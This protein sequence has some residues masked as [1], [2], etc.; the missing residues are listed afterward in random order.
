MLPSL[1]I[2]TWNIFRKSKEITLWQHIVSSIT[3]IFDNFFQDAFLFVCLPY[4]AYYSLDAI[5]RTGWRMIISHKKLLE[6]TPSN[7]QEHTSDRT[8]ATAYWSMWF[9]PALA[10]ASFVYITICDPTRLFFAFPVLALWALSPFVAWWVSK[11]FKKYESKLTVVQV[12]YL[13]KIARKTWAFFEN[14]VGPEDNWLPVDNYQ[15]RPNNAVAH[16]TSPTNI[17]L[18]LLA[19]LSAYDFGYIT[20]GRLLRN[21]SNTINT[22]GKMERYEGHLYNWY[23]TVTLKPLHPRYVSTVDSGNLAGHLL[24][25]KQG[26]LAIADEKLTPRKLFEGLL[27]TAAIIETELP[28]SA[29]LKEL[30]NKIQATL[31]EPVISPGQAISI[32]RWLEQA[33]TDITAGI[34]PE[35]EAQWWTAALSQQCATIAEEL[36]NLLPWLSLSA[37]IKY[38]ALFD[39]IR[40]T[41]LQEIAALEVTL[42]PE[43]K[44]IAT[45]NTSE[46]TEWLKLFISNINA[47]AGHAN[48]LIDTIEQLAIS[49]DEFADM[50]YE[51]LYDRSKHLLAIGFNVEEHTRDTGFYD[52]LASEARLCS[53]VAI[54]Q[55]KLPQ[56]TWFALGRLLTNAKGTPILLS[57]SGSMFEYLMPML[58]MPTYENTLLE[59]THKAAVARQIEYGNERE[60]PWGISESGY[61]MLD[62][63]LNYQYRAFGVP[64]LGLKRGLAEDLVIAPYA[65]ALALMVAPEE[66]CSNMERISAAGFEGRYG[67]FEAIDYTP[68]RVPRGQTNAV[69][70]SYMAHHQGMSIVSIAYALLRQPMQ[71]RFEAELQFQATLLLLQERIPKTTTYYAH[72]TD[73]AAVNNVT[74]NTEMRVITTP[75][76]QIPE[77]QLLSNGKYHVMITNAGGGYSRWKDVAVTRWH[78]DTTCDN[79]GTFCYIRDLEDGAFWSNAHQPAL[80]PAKNYE[81]TFTQGRAE[82]RRRDNGIETHTEVVVSPEDDIEMRRIHITNRSLRRRSIEITSYAEVVLTDAATDT[83]HPAF[84][85]LFVQTEIIKQRCAIICTRRPRSVDEHPPSMFHLVT[86]QGANAKESIL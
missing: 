50:N 39:S 55:G 14:F 49:C 62:T 42:L 40:A 24:T 74:G 76:T 27:D 81:A 22:L 9:S 53:F 17:G 16:R 28:G 41:T 37:P 6:W 21:T 84:S 61:N 13:R 43:I 86:I 20:I 8:I 25:L 75:N 34:Q 19:N 10:L 12:A 36:T 57:W 65:T 83:V 72:S 38:K 85:N 73:I 71:K 2:S 51:F 69:L 4:E 80:I 47:A 35:S 46:E 63:N 52:L 60:V 58:V 68:S 77:I 7:N 45:E 59:Q 32:A 31:N 5:V 82:F 26:V 54:A 56:E 64:G 44:A 3:V 23:D 70:Q 11:P 30:Q 18:A 67:L 1:I 66:A 78:E 29:K 15:V 33:C 79:W 48:E